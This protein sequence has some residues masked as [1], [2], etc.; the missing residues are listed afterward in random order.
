MRSHLLFFGL[1]G[2]NDRDTGSKANW[3]R[4]APPQI[5]LQGLREEPS[6]PLQ[7]RPPLKG[8]LAAHLLPQ[9]P[10]LSSTPQPP[11]GEYVAVPLP[12]HRVTEMVA[13]SVCCLTG[14]TDSQPEMS[15]CVERLEF[16]NE[17]ETQ[18]GKEAWC[19]SSGL[20]PST[21]A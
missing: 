5:C 19:R 8:L 1:Y 15:L 3:N 4:A 16:G 18:E 14:S 10:Q 20:T 7:L 12:G 2:L 21:T 11:L 17:P 9:S 6:T 13:L